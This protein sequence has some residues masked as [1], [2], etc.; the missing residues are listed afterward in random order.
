MAEIILRELSYQIVGAAMEV[1]R[2]LGPGFL[3]AVYQ[4][5]LAHELGLCGLRFEEQTHLCVR[6]KGLVVGEY[7]ADMLVEDQIILELKAISALTP[8]HAAQAHNYL[9]ATGL[10]LAILLNFGTP[11]LQQKRI[12]RKAT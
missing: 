3:E 9:T 7:I 2:V 6:Y 8:A 4:R 12:I 10:N 11:S 1:H 5:S